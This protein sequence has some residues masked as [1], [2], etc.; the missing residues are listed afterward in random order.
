MPP[1]KR[2]KRK[3]KK[4]A[5]QK[6]AAAVNL[7][8]PCIL[9]PPLARLLGYQRKSRQ[10]VTKDIWAYVKRN[11]LQDP[12][13]GRRILCDSALKAVFQVPI[14]TMM[15]LSGALTRHLHKSA[16]G[17]TAA[18]PVVMPSSSGASSSATARHQL[19]VAPRRQQPRPDSLPVDNFSAGL[20]KFLHATMGPTQLESLQ[21]NAVHVKLHICNWAAKNRLCDEKDRHHINCDSLLHELFKCSSF[22]VE[23][24]IELLQPHIGGGASAAIATSPPVSEVSP[25][26]K[27]RRVVISSSDDDSDTELC[28]LPAVRAQGDEEGSSGSEATEDYDS[29]ED[30]NEG[31]ATTAG[32]HNDDVSG[33]H[34]EGNQAGE[35]LSL[36]DEFLEGVGILQYRGIFESHGVG[37][38]TIFDLSKEDLEKKLG[39]PGEVCSKLL[40]ATAPADPMVPTPKRPPD[41]CTLEQSKLVQKEVQ[42]REIDPND[43][44]ETHQLRHQVEALQDEVDMQHQIL[45]PLLAKERDTNDQLRNA[46][47]QALQAHDRGF[48]VPVRTMGLLDSKVMRK[49]AR[50][51]RISEEEISQ[52]QDV[53]L[54]D[55]NFR[56]VRMVLKPGSTDE[57][58]QIPYREDKEL[59]RIK[60]KYGTDVAEAVLKAFQELD[61]WNPSGRYTVRIP[62]CEK[63]GRE[64]QP[65]EVTALIMSS[66]PTPKRRPRG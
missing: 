9:S 37:I 63:L 2:K 28:I 39:L 8:R 29:E 36:L 46:R 27:K 5:E 35:E 3:K 47:E 23:R 50:N 7:Q 11:Q 13:D 55:P 1:K 31:E 65:A 16:P 54:R 38:E 15:T 62:Y 12:S 20:R 59:L 17:T 52:L 61:E 60:A 4:T 53:L 42:S 66:A 57:M 34:G 51:G 58:E 18:C 33:S 26:R 21:S 6:A 41:D 48:P 10:E 40:A 32:G 30:G 19:G 14:L 56:P 24:L 45:G 43:S 49:A 44:A 22:R 25:A 64:L